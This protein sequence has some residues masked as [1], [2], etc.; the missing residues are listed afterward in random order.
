[1]KLLLDITRKRQFKLW[2]LIICDFFFSIGLIDFILKND[3]FYFKKIFETNQLIGFL[4]FWILL[5]YVRG[6]YL[7]STAENILLKSIKDIREIIIVS[8]MIL[9]FTFALKILSIQDSLLQRIY[10]L[11]IVF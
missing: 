9:I 4:L 8:S 11:F 3:F 6:R 1:M 10:Y 2:I 5:S 7:L